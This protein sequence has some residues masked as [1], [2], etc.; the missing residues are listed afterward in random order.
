MKK[1]LFFPIFTLLLISCEKE[2]LKDKTDYEFEKS[3]SS[4]VA[5]FTFNESLDDQSMY[6]I[7]S[8]ALN[9]ELTMDFYGNENSAAYFNGNSYIEILSENIINYTNKNFTVCAWIKPKVNEYAYVIT[10]TANKYENGNL[11][12]GGG[13]YSL[14]YYPGTLRSIVRVENYEDEN[15]IEI[16]GKT[17]ISPNTWQHISLTWNEGKASLFYNGKLENYGQH[18]INQILQTNGNTYIGAYKWAFPNASYK[19]SIDNVRI[20]NRALSSIEIVK[21]FDE[22]K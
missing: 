7:N 11:P 22:H 1:I 16:F 17:Y 21:L 6:N 10:K 4:L 3:D 2:V 5:Y 13:P 19:G 8:E 15:M 18:N 14:D 20:Y 9:V 12:H